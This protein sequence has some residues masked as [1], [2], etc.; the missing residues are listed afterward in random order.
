MTI[1]TNPNQ[2]QQNSAIT[3]FTNKDKNKI[4]KQL[5]S[6]KDIEAF[7]AMIGKPQNFKHEEHISFS[8]KADNFDVCM[9]AVL[10]LRIDNHKI[11]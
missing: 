6:S 3:N 8:N 1:N 2:I 10:Y 11:Y 5:K 9:R 4:K 7:K